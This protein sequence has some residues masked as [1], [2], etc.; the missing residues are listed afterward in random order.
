MVRRVVLK[1][2]ALLGLL[3]L[4]ACIETRPLD[5][6]DLLAPLTHDYKSQIIAWAKLFFADPASLRG[7]RISKPLSVE[8]RTQVPLWLVCVDVDVRGPDGAFI[9]PQ[10]LAF[11]FSGGVMQSAPQ[12]RGVTSLA[13]ADCDRFPLAWNA[14]PELERIK[15]PPQLR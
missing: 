15:A 3:F 8:D 9:G 6:P 4:Q 12:R 10:R 1:R 11:G 7:A 13:S 2:S 5:R 14:F